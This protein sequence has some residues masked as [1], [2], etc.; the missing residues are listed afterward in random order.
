MSTAENK[1]LTRRFL[2]EGINQSNEPVFLNLLDP[3]VVDH[4][5]PPCLPPGREGWNLN[6]KMFRSAFPDGRWIEQAMIAEGD[7]VMG[8]YIFRGTHQGEFF[9]IPPT[10]KTIT[11]SN[12]HILHFKDGKIVEHW[13]N[14]DDLGMLQQ[15]GVI[16]LPGQGTN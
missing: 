7:L 6:R 12:I 11:V 13:G 14:G 4:Y 5:A 1:A 2:E 8:R 10:G 15:L 16:T 9:G 3:D